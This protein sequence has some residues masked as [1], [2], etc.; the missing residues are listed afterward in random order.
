M[1]ILTTWIAVLI[2]TFNVLVSVKRETIIKN[3]KIFLLNI[4][5]AK[6]IRIERAGNHKYCGIR[7]ANDN[8]KIEIET[9]VLFLSN[10]TFI[11]NNRF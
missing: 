2:L 10:N 11:A 4:L 5:N 3:M 6:N 7:S 1:K 9:A 8:T